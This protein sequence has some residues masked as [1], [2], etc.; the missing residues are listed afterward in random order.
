MPVETA[1]KTKTLTNIGIPREIYNS[2]LSKSYDELNDFIDDD[3]YDVAL[4]ERQE[5][6]CSNFVRIPKLLLEKELK[7]EEDKLIFFMS[8]HFF[9]YRN[10]YNKI[11]MSNSDIKN[12]FFVDRKIKELKNSIV[13]SHDIIDIQYVRPC[14]ILTP[15][16]KNSESVITDSNLN[17]DTCDNES[18]NNIKKIEQELFDLKM[19]YGSDA[20]LN[21]DYIAK[22]KELSYIIRKISDSLLF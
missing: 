3:I 4:Q 10:R 13:G 15:S 16:S 22:Q 6:G 17:C 2:L 19:K 20:C 18:G 7:S 14:I 12:K 21:D 8:I 5:K 11:S 9:N 1:V